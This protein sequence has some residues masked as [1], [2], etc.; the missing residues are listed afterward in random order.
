MTLMLFFVLEQLS[1]EL[2]GQAVDGD[3]EVVL[4]VFGKQMGSLNVNSRLGLLSV[5][6]DRQDDVDFHNPFE[7]T[8]E[9]LEFFE[10][11][12][13]DAFRHFNVVAGNF[14]LHGFR[15]DC[16]KTNSEKLLALA[17]RG[18]IQGFSVFCNGS[19]GYID[20]A[21]LENGRNRVIAE[22][23]TM[24]LGLNNLLQKGLDGRG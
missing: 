13:P 24:I 18:N 6:F 7:V 12:G 14:D 11:V 4:G 17:G 9:P 8:I 22:R 1:V 21:L 3:I 23:F 2:V 20:S 16:G 5:R 19:P 10:H 15:L